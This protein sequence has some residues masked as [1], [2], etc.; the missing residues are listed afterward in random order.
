MLN[1]R[2]AFIGGG[3]MSEG[4]IRGIINTETMN[5]DKI[6]VCEVIPQ[7]REYLNNTYNITVTGNSAEAIKEAEIIFLAVRPQNVEESLKEISS[8]LNQNQMLISICAGIDLSKLD[9]WTG[10]HKKIARVMP[11]V[12]IEARHG[13]SGVCS[14]KDITEYDKTIIKELFSAIGQTM[15]ID[16]SLFN[17]F[18]AYS[19]VGPAYVMYFIAALVDGGVK[20]GFSRSDSTAIAIENLIGSAKMI[21]IT[22][23]HPYQITDAM[24][25]PAGMTI[26]ALH[27]LSKS[28]FHGI[29]MDS[30]DAAVKR[31]N[32][33]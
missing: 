10:G 29:V 31:V 19:C 23:K 30:V 27:V 24:T 13:F 12:L 22:K 26:E 11:N 17:V 9:L 5:P 21:D 15:F 20:A 28:G 18:S 8:E 6:T 4:I 7:R 33:F 25:S 1:K 14:S 3:N 16:E 2:L 32:E